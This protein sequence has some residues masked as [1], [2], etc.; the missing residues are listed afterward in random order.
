[1]RAFRALIH[2][3]GIILNPSAVPYF[4]QHFQ[5]I[6]GTLFQPL[7]FEQFLLRFKKGQALFQFRLD[8]NDRLAQPFF[9]GDEV[10][11]GINGHC[12]Q[13]SPQLAGDSI[14]L[15]DAFDLIPEKSD[16][17]SIAVLIGW[18]DL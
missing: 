6:Q 16:A 15:D 9:L 4:T 13:A 7:G 8:I 12:R 10:L 18:D 1:M 14:E 11:G 17:I 3:A 5:V 2:V